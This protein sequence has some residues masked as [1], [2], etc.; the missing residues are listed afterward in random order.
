MISDPI[1]D[2]LTRIRNGYLARKEQV[3]LP[4]SVFKSEIANLLVNLGYLQTAKKSE[5]NG[6][7]TLEL[8][9]KYKDGVPALTAIDRVSKPSLRIY[10]PYNK[11]PVVL[12]GLGQAVVSTSQGLMTGRDAK[13]KKLG[14]ELILRV[15]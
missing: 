11:M 13:K 2:M 9:L 15:Y 5:T 14:G 6:K 4:S 8:T 7:I 10:R 3:S 12:S 1:S